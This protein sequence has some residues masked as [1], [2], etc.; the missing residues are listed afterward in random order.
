MESFAKFDGSEMSSILIHFP[1]NVDA[2][3]NVKHD[4]TILFKFPHRLMHRR[5]N[6]DGGLV[7]SFNLYTFVTN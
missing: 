3:I 1:S 7:Y 2:E 5:M 4:V 6:L